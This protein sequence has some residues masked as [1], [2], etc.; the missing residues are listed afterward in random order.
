MADFSNTFFELVPAEEADFDPDDEVVVADPDEFPAEEDERLPF[1]LTWAFDPDTG[2][3]ATYGTMAV[4]VSGPDS[5][6]IW[7]LVA[8]NSKRFAHEIFS[9]DFGMEV[10]D[11]LIGFQYEAERNADYIRDVRET[12]L[13][14]DRIADVR[15]FTFRYNDDEEHVEMD[16]EIILDDEDATTISLE[17][18][19]L[20]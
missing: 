6:K 3:V 17:A 13:V 14:H 10:P 7:A 4:E 19:T 2:Q 16:A 11:R 9:D 20:G 1:G 12:L 5:V 15:D 8:L 18:V